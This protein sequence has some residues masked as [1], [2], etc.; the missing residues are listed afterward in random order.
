MYVRCLS[1]LILHQVVHV[2]TYTS[3]CSLGPPMKVGGFMQWA[4]QSEAEACRCVQTLNSLE[5]CSWVLTLGNDERIASV[6]KQHR[7]ACRL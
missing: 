7:G 2:F 3:K 1:C 6:A 4:L 5:D